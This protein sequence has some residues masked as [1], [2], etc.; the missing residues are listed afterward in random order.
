MLSVPS[1]YLRA[2]TA[3]FARYNT[4]FAL[5]LLRK[6]GRDRYLASR[7]NDQRDLAVQTA[8]RG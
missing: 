8:R 5:S 2:P 6:G 7:S 1:E 3:D 4:S